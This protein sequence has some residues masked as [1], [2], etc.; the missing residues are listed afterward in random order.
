LATPEKPRLRGA[1]SPKALERGSSVH[2]DD[3]RYYE[4]T[5]ASRD[6]DVVFYEALVRGRHPRPNPG[7]ARAKERAADTPYRVLEIGIGHGR[8]ALPLAR[9]GADVTGVDLSA[10]MLEELARRLTQEP[11]EVRARIHAHHGDMRKLET[12]LGPT[13]QPFPL[14]VATFN[15]FLHLYERVDV[16]A[17]LAGVRALLAP[18][19]HFVM[20]VSVPH[21]EDLARDPERAYGAPRFRDPASGKLVRYAERFDYDAASQVLFVSME[22]TPVDGSAPWGQPLA[23]R[24]FF[25]QE[26]EAL[27][28]YNGFSLVSVH[29]GFEGEPLDRFSDQAVWTFA[30]TPPARLFVRK[31]AEVAEVE[32]VADRSDGDLRREVGGEPRV[33]R[34]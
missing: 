30:A 20:D 33:R 4:K 15:T 2:Y 34:G 32:A 22:F 13:T 24:Q 18:G 11:P 28:H 10:P 25:P 21:P 19:G 12:V 9:A 31:L 26:I 27:F 7:G 6:E 5:Y 3:V 17:F 29:G 8:I 14:I 23:H 16:E 1:F